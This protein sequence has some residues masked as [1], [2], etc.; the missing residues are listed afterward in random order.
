MSRPPAV[1]VR[2]SRLSLA[3]LW[4]QILDCLQIDTGTTDIYL[5]CGVVLYNTILGNSFGAELPNAYLPTYP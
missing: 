4:L 1:F 2:D 3:D 5:Q